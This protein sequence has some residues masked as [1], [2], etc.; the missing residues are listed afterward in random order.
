MG[1][2]N[3][4]SLFAAVA[5]PFLATLHPQE[6]WDNQ[7]TGLGPYFWFLTPAIIFVTWKAIC[8]RENKVTY[9]FLFRLI[10]PATGFYLLWVA[11]PGVGLFTRHLVPIYPLLL[12]AV[13]SGIYA[14]MVRH[15][16]AWLRYC[17]ITSM[18]LSIMIGFGIQFL[19]GQNYGKFHLSSE[20]RDEFYRRNIS[21]Y[22]GIEWVNKN[23]SRS[24]KLAHHSRYHNYLLSNPYI[25]ISPRMQVTIPPD[26]VDDIEHIRRAFCEQKVE[27][28]MFVGESP[29]YQ[30]AFNFEIVSTERSRQILSRTIVNLSPLSNKGLG[31]QKESAASAVLDTKIAYESNA[32]ISVARLKWEEVDSHQNCV[33]PQDEG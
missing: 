20:T 28:L 15:A 8:S 11:I 24:T 3:L 9:S 10:F 12:I 30:N 4:E 2:C 14:Y 1:G 18:T 22:E 25:L 5:Y 13:S 16:V 21:Y 33:K 31:M 26:G 6:C 17:L 32:S 19:Y 27:Y 29:P 23:L 7:R